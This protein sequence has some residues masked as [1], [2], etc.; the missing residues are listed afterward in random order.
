VNV[1]LPGFR[2]C[3]EA[4]AALSIV[5]GFRAAVAG[6]RAE[7]GL[8]HEATIIGAFPVIAG[9]LVQRASGFDPV[10]PDPT[11]SHAADTL[12]MLLDRKPDAREVAAL[13]AYL[14]TACDHGMNASTFAHPRRGLDAGRSICVGD[15]GI[16]R[17]DRTAAR[18]RSRAGA[19]NARRYRQPRAHQAMGRQRAGAG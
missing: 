13:D 3:S 4:R 16:L 7:S 18:R 12:S 6:L 19:G 1:L 17:A 2:T 5:D 14:V 8:A 10:A 9:A 15:G 11:T